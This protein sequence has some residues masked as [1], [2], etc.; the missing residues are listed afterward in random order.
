MLCL[1][2]E[3]RPEKKEAEERNKGRDFA[4]TL[5]C[6]QGRENMCGSVQLHLE[7]INREVIRDNS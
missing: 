1:S 4:G 7:M 3:E 5:M 2:H 6:W